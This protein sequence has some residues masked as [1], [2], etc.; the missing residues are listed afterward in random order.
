MRVCKHFAVL[1]MQCVLLALAFAML[2]RAAPVL[3]LKLEKTE[4]IETFARALPA[5]VNIGFKIP[6]QWAQERL[7]IP[8]PEDGEDVLTHLH[9]G[10]GDGD[11]RGK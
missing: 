7:G 10:H 11:R 9:N 2:P 3:R 4:D 6:T 8:Q 1:A 5:L